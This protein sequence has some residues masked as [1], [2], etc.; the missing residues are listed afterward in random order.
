MTGLHT[1]A[2]RQ[3]VAALAQARRD[4]GLTQRDL[5]ARLE[6]SQVYVAKYEMARQRLDV[7]EFLRVCR[8]IGVDP[9]RMIERL[10]TSSLA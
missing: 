7:I 10:K 8:A 5:A 1:D 2:Y 9:V 6:V 3:L 4:A